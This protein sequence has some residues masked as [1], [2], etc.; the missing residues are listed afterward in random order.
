MKT[1]FKRLRDDLDALFSFDRQPPKVLLFVIFS[2]PLGLMLHDL[3][4]PDQHPASPVI[5]YLAGGFIAWA[6]IRGATPEPDPGETVNFRDPTS[7]VPLIA[8]LV[9][10]LGGRVNVPEAELRCMVGRRLYA[11]RG[12]AG[13]GG[14]VVEVTEEP[15]G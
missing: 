14:L 6:L 10:R 3:G 11:T 4:L 9:K 7:S 12:D 2:V 1:N 15:R 8:A 5:T 13:R